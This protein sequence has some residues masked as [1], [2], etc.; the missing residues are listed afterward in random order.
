MFL[1]SVGTEHTR[2]PQCTHHQ[3][4][5]ASVH[6]L[7]VAARAQRGASCYAGRREVTRE[8]VLSPQNK[9]WRGRARD[10]TRVESPG[11]W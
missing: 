10:R 3:G 1:R 11:P 9:P 5:V 2:R 7:Q 6:V 4:S 8:D